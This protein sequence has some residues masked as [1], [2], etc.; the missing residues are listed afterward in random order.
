MKQA[1]KQAPLAVTYK[2]DTGESYGPRTVEK[3]RHYVQFLKKRN[4]AKKK[5]IVKKNLAGAHVDEAQYP[6]EIMF[7][8]AV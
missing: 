6:F 2:D 3:F 5:E 7:S 4:Q 1:K 8:D